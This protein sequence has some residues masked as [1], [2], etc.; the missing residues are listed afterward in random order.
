MFGSLARL[1]FCLILSIHIMAG[2]ICC[3][4]MLCKTLF[5]KSQSASLPLLHVCPKKIACLM[6]LYEEVWRNRQ[7]EMEKTIQKS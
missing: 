7:E 6:P 1:I 5:L 2:I 4:N 3:H